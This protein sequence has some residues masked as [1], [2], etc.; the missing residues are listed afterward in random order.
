V[1]ATGVISG[2][3]LHCGTRRPRMKYQDEI[4][5]V[6]NWVYHDSHWYATL[7]TGCTP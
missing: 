6:S 3:M 1:K 2:S 7:G 5:I 4:R